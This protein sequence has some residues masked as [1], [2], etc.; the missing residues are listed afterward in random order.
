MVVHTSKFLPRGGFAQGQNRPNIC[1]NSNNKTKAEKGRVH[2]ITQEPKDKYHKE[3]LAVLEQG[4][5]VEIRYNPDVH[6]KLYISWS[7]IEEESFA[8]FGSGNLTSSGISYNLEL[9]MMI[10][11]RGYGRK[12]VREL[13]N[14]GDVLRTRSH[15][16]KSIR[17]NIT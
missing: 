13:Y 3:G 5:N 7:R 15:K 6:A 12:L 16:I 17:A 8:M 14:W 2:V 10:L 11:A 9:G 4:E 1:L